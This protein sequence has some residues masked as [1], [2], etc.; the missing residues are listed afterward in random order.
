M[1]RLLPAIA[2]LHKSSAE[3]PISCAKP[4]HF[5]FLTINFTF[6][7]QILSTGGDALSTQYQPNICTESFHMVLV[8]VLDLFQHFHINLVLDLSGRGSRLICA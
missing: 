6:W 5:D 7:S 8:L 3:K 4:A 2:K 1:L